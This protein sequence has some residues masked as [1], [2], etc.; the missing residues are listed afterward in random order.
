MGLEIFEMNL[1]RYHKFVVI[2]SDGVFEFL[3]NREIACIVAPF[4]ETRDA[5]KAAEAVVRESYLRW[6]KADKGI[7]D[8]ITCV[9]VF[10]DCK[11]EK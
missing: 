8:D 2:G 1:G 11:L 4:H 5:E 7:V 3:S 9:I 6:K 10:L